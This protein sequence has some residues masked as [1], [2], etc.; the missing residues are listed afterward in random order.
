MCAKIHALKSIAQCF[1]ELMVNLLTHVLYSSTF[2]SAV[3]LFRRAIVTFVATLTHRSY[4]HE[5]H[6]HRG[7]TAIEHTVSEVK[8]HNSKHVIPQSHKTVIACANYLVTIVLHPD[9]H[10]HTGLYL[11]T[12]FKP[13]VDY[14]SLSLMLVFIQSA[15]SFVF[16]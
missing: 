8:Q 15:N 16:Q 5:S 7:K 3:S 1:T 10:Q 4:H 9:D 14:H 6:T 2:H 11:R 13:F 12:I